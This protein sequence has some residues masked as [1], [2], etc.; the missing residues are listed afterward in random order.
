LGAWPTPIRRLDRTS[1]ELGTEVWVKIEEECGAWGGNKVR[2]LEYILAHARNKDAKSLV[3]YGA[4]T[5]SW[6]AALVLHGTE[7]GFKVVLGLGGQ[8]PDHYRALYERRGVSVHTASSHS[9]TP[10]AAA[11][12]VIAAGPRA[13]RLAAGG[14]DR[15]G[16]LGAMAAGAE[17]ARAVEKRYLPHPRA[18]FVPAGTSGTAAGIAVGLGVAGT[19]IP[20]VAVRVTPLPL[21]TSTLV[22][23]HAGLLLRFLR[24]HGGADAGAVAAPIE[25]D[26]HYFKPGYGASNEASTE[27]IEI[28]GR[29]G[30]ELDPTYAAKAFAAL[31]GAARA[32]RRGPLLFHHTSPGPLPEGA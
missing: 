9:L 17:I 21:G 30:L 4:G 10:L 32:G 13:L 3:T 22:A 1:E 2:K 26:S 31:I 28:A 29:D 24:S 8:I 23:Y 7:M 20:V 15:R 6:A 14:S 5:S 16:D 11:K 19:R 27:A 18:I 12:A 25:G